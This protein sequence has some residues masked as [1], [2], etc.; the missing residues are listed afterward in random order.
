MLH[1][2]FSKDV[3]IYKNITYTKPHIYAKSIMY[4]SK[5]KT[6]QSYTYKNIGKPR[7]TPHTLATS[8]TNASLKI[9]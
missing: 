3:Q 1:D 9:K 2:M 7:F 6:S 4:V 5:S 8:V